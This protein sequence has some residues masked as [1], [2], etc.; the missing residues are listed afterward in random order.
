MNGSQLL[1]SLFR[2]LE[3]DS[4]FFFVASAFFRFRLLDIGEVKMVE[5]QIKHEN[6]HNF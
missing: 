6:T 5:L 4:C 2:L 1:N 3:V